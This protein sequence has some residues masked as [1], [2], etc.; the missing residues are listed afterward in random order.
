MVSP[1][2]NFSGIASGLDT[3]SIVSQLMQI[4]RAPITRLQVQRA[5]YEDRRDAWTS[6]TTK[7]SEFRTALDSARYASDFDA[8]TTVT[9]TNEDAVS[10]SASGSSRRW[11]GLWSGSSFSPL[12]FAPRSA[13][14]LSRPMRP[15]SPMRSTSSPAS[16]G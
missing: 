4:E 10:I 11:C 16:A 15:T 8:F 2:F 14:R 3:N 6:I 1:T 13:C 9:S 12:G 7:L 5:E